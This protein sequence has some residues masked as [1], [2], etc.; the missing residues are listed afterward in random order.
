MA[1]IKDLTKTGGKVVAGAVLGVALGLTQVDQAK[2]NAVQDA[3]VIE[4]VASKKNEKTKEHIKSDVVEEAYVLTVEETDST[5][6][7][8]GVVTSYNM[9]R[10]VIRP[11]QTVKVDSIGVGDTIRV[12]TFVNSV[13][14][15]EWV[16][17]VTQQPDDK[18]VTKADIQIKLF[19]QVS[20][21]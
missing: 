11:E 5:G 3:T 9:P 13:V 8:T 14:T 12:V 1:D 20:R 18:K 19:D 6:V 21:E 15:D 4:I 10:Q 17:V 16:S 7:K 2:I